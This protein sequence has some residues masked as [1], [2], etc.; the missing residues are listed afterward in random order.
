MNLKKKMLIV[1]LLIAIFPKISFAENSTFKVTVDGKDASV[2]EDTLTGTT[3]YSNMNV[4]VYEDAD[5]G[6][7]LVYEGLLG[8]YDNGAWSNVDFGQIDF[9]VIFNW[10]SEDVLYV[11][12]VKT[13][14]NTNNQTTTN[15]TANN[16]PQYLSDNTSSLSIASQI[17]INGV[18][19]GEKGMRI[20]D[21]ANLTCHFAIT[22]NSTTP[23][24]NEC[25]ISDI[26][27]NK[28]DKHLQMPICKQTR[29]R[30]A[31]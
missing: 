6:K 17:R 19:V 5:G 21:N 28:K 29:S 25:N 16:Q 10:D 31:C 7:K 3:D 13:S 24:K 2:V 14:A 4:L 15:T 27:R 20:I 18:N 9:L 8:E 12:P 1:T 23:Q 22:N 26:Y 11:Q 30:I